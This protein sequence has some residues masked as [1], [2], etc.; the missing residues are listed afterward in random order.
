LFF[1][2]AS[3]RGAASPP[4]PS[5]S[6]GYAT[7]LSGHLSP[8][9]SLFRTLLSLAPRQGGDLRLHPVAPDVLLYRGYFSN[10]AVL[11]LPRS[12]VVV[13]SQVTPRAAQPLLAQLRALTDRP[14]RVVF[15]THH[16]GDHVGGNAAFAGAS[17]VASADTARFMV[18]RADERLR[19]ARTFGLEVQE[20]PPPVLPTRTFDQRLSLELDGERLELFRCGQ[21]ETPDAAVLWWPARGVLASGDGVATAGYPYLGVPFLDEGLKD[22][23]QWPG[24]LARLRSLNAR[25]LLPGHGP[26]LVGRQAIARRLDL[27]A[28]LMRDLLAATRAELERPERPLPE[29][30]EAIDAR[31]ARYRER[32]DLEQSVATQRF[33]IYRA[34]NGCLP[35]RQGLGWWEDLRPPALSI[36]GDE[37]ADAELAR[38]AAAS[39]SAG[40][41]EDLPAGRAAA[42]VGSGRRDLA[43]A[44]L[45][46]W[47]QRHPG[48]AAGHGLLSELFMAGAAEVPSKID[49]TDYTRAAAGAAREALALD[50]AA[51]L[52]LLNLGTIEI[53]SALIAGQDPAAG[54]ARV[55]A[56]LQSGTLDRG[57]RRR[58]RFALAKAH[59]AAFRPAEADR[60]LRDL[61]PGWA[62]PLFPLLRTRLR[63]LP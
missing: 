6:A 29:L 36:A 54:A 58:G 46:R 14:V 38:L 59:Q 61:L 57:Q 13:D 63:S 40:T 26:A 32:R 24:Y 30:V 9:R 12:V 20:V 19:Y 35:G 51:P 21:V 3:G 62:R 42:L 55:Q 17:I 28:A 4:C 11:L 34:L 41:P 23:G 22:D 33:A 8:L 60:E 49:A 18:E 44:L 43:L 1:S 39:R 56:A 7:G 2:S 45:R 31:L 25:V 5:R 53:L 50:P 52:A 37:E 48:S 15:N 47:L 16:H 27:L 10:S